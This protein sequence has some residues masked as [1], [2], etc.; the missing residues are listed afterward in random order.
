MQSIGN[1][2]ALHHGAVLVGSPGLAEHCCP[3]GPPSFATSI[4]SFLWFALSFYHDLCTLEKLLAS[5]V[6]FLLAILFEMGAQVRWG[7]LVHSDPDIS[8]VNL[9]TVKKFLCKEVI[10]TKLCNCHYGAESLFH[11]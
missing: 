2:L 7:E 1:H 8:G 6:L 9:A 5:P 4:S 11:G 3:Q 10:V